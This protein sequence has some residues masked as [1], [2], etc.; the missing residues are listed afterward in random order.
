MD[1]YSGSR[2]TL[3]V[4]KRKDIFPLFSELRAYLSRGITIQE[5]EL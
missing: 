5:T 1:A 3:E 2:G 4:V